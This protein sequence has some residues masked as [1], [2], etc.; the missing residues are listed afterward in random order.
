MHTLQLCIES[1]GDQQPGDQQNNTMFSTARSHDNLYSFA[2]AWST[3][4]DGIGTPC[5]VPGLP[6]SILLV[7]HVQSVGH[8]KMQLLQGVSSGLQAEQGTEYPEKLPRF[9]AV[10][11]PLVP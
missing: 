4:L 2:E 10:L 8:T 9:L 6:V 11:M 7:H 3:E 1:L 5:F